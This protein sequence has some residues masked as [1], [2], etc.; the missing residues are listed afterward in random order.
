MQNATQS[1]TNVASR[2]CQ[3]NGCEADKAID[4]S[5]T[6]FARTGNSQFNWWAVEL[7]ELVEIKN[8]FVSTTY[9]GRN[10]LTGF[11]VETKMNESE[12]WELCKGPYS[13]EGDFTP[14]MVQCENMTIAG[15]LRLSCTGKYLL[16]TDVKI[17]GQYISYTQT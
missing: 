13:V 11:K 6:T 16:L 1:S 9:A 7:T 15:Y 5:L 17:E 10:R 2:K 12:P 4:D 8:V 14:H 3:Q